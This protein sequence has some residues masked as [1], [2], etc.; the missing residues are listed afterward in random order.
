[1]DLREA[2]EKAGFGWA[3]SHTLRK[4]TAAIVDANGLTA[5]E[6]ADQLG[7]SRMN[8]AQDRYLGRQY[9]RRSGQGSRVAQSNSPR[10]TA[11]RNGTHPARGTLKIEP[12][13]FLLSR[14][15]CSSPSRSATS[16]HAPPVPLL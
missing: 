14:T 5:R 6:I 15:A 10:C 3:T 11:S 1:V 13:G 8:L 16:T 12:L 9:A 7:H 4:T 2:F